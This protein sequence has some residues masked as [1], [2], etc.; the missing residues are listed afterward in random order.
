MRKRLPV[1]EE[2]GVGLSVLPTLPT[3]ARFE[4]LSVGMATETSPRYDHDSRRRPDGLLIQATLEGAGRVG[5]SRKRHARPIRAGQ[6]LVLRFPSD[7]R[8][9]LEPGR[10]WRFLWVILGGAPALAL[11]QHLLDTHGQVITLPPAAPPLTTMRD[12]Y[13]RA[14]S[15]AKPDELALS[16]DSHRLLIELLR[17]QQPAEARL[18]PPI[19]AARDLIEQRF[20]DTSLGVDDLG[21]AAGY[22]RYHFSRL[23]KQHT[24][25]TPYQ[26]L[27]RRRIRHALGLLAT[28]DEPIKRVALLS[29][30]N[31]ASWFCAA[32]RRQTGASPGAAR[33]QRS[34]R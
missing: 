7:T 27:L 31:D 8:Y 1:I 18:P 28:T 16:L 25:L 14:I 33:K 34:V 26:Y 2:R 29:G 9:W 22:S 19:A 10:T 17:T 11:G 4:L 23:F 21:D 12:L 5:D 32:F 6:A 13:Q 30:F 20:A 15:D 3:A 24:G